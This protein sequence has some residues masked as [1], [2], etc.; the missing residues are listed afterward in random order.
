MYKSA[1]T[2]QEASKPIRE[3]TEQMVE[4]LP[5]KTKN[6]FKNKPAIFLI[7]G[8]AVAAGVFAFLKFKSKKAGTTKVQNLAQNTAQM[9]TA[10][11]S[12]AVSN[13]ISQNMAVPKPAQNA[14]PKMQSVDE[15]LKALQAM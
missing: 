8:G 7:A 1:E 6:I 12:S 2:L 10:V 5:Q 15:F 3:A 4:E 9:S 11:Q 13:K 14:I